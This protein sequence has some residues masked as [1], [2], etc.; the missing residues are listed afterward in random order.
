[1]R[2]RNVLFAAM[3]IGFS[4]GGASATTIQ[5]HVTFGAG[6]FTA[7]PPGAEPPIL[8]TGAFDID[9]DVG[10]SVPADNTSGLHNTTISASNTFS[11]DPFPF[12]VD[13]PWSF[14]Y[15]QVNDILLVGGSSHGASSIQFSPAENDFYLQIHAFSTATPLMW[16]LGFAQSRI[17]DTQFYN[18]AG[19]APSDGYVFVTAGGPV[20]TTPLPAGLPLFLTALGAIGLVRSRKRSGMLAPLSVQR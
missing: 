16:Q 17:P 15:D 8:V 3:L 1:M 19:G 12:Q 9:L 2:I 14:T 5:Y 6:N 4:A 10:A 20:A 13:S 18:P 7:A 11:G